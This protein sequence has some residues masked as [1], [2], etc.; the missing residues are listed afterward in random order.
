MGPGRSE[1]LIL[2]RLVGESNGSDCSG[3][4]E[5]GVRQS[6]GPEGE[7]GVVGK[8]NGSQGERG[9]DGGDCDE[10][11]GYSDEV[12]DDESDDGDLDKGGDSESVEE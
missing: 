2:R 8:S 11:R 6:N 4:G 3:E 7:D 10:E 1:R 12:D 5:S 9:V